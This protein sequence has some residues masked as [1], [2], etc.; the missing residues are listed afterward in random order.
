MPDILDGR[1]NFSVDQ[2]FEILERVQDGIMV[3][4]H[5]LV[6]TYANEQAGRMLGQHSRQLTGMH[7]AGLFQGAQF[8]EQAATCIQNQRVVEFEGGE[9]RP[10][11]RCACSL[12]PTPGGLISLMRVVTGTHHESLNDRTE[13]GSPDAVLQAKT[14][15]LQAANQD[16][17][18]GLAEKDLMLQIS[19]TLIA[20]EK[21]EDAIQRVADILA[22]A[23]QFDR[24]ILLTFDLG[25][26]Q[27]TGRYK[28]G[29]GVDAIFDVDFDELWDGL[30]GW[31]L[32]ERKPALSPCGTLDERESPEVRKRRTETNCGAVAVVP[33]LLQD[34]LIGTL[35]AIN[36]LDQ[37]DI[38]AADLNL[39]VLLSHQVAQTIENNR[40]YR[41]LAGEVET[42]KRAQEALLAA[43]AGL[44]ERVQQRTNELS[45][46]NRAL[47]TLSDCNQV[48]VRSGSEK[49]LMAEICQILVTTGGYHLAWV[50]YLEHNA[51]K[52]IRPV[53]WAGFEDGYLDTLH[54]T[55]IDSERG[56]G[57]TGCAARTRRISVARDVTR[58]PNFAP[59]R[60]QA[61]LRGYHSVIGVPMMLG[62]EIIGVLTIYSTRVDAFPQSEQDLLV[63]LA[64]DLA[65]GIMA[66]R[67][68]QERINLEER[69]TKAFRASP[70]AMIIA[71]M[72]DSL[73]VEVN[74]S[75]LELIGYAR[76]DLVG[77]FSRDTFSF[78]DPNEFARLRQIQEREN[79][80]HHVE[81][82]IRR[83]SGEIRDVIISIDH[84][85]INNQPH[86]LMTLVDVSDIKKMEQA[87]RES[88]TMYRLVSENTADA[89]WTIDPQTLK[90]TYVSPSVVKVH[91]F[92]AE[93]LLGAPLEMVLPPGGG[94]IIGP[95]IHERVEIFLKRGEP[96][97]FVDELDLMRKDGTPVSAEITS[98]YVRD[99]NG[100]MQVVGV[101]RDISE[102]KR[103]DALL[104]K[105]Q[106]SLEAAQA[107][108]H[109][110]SWE[111]DL[112]SGQGA[113][114]KEMFK[115]FGRDPADG[116]PEFAEFLNTIHYDDRDTLMAAHGRALETGELVTVEYRIILPKAQSGEDNH[117]VRHLESRM[118]KESGGPTGSRLAG[119][120]LD[121][122]TR[123]L[124][125]INLGERMKEL[126]CLQNVGKLLE[127]E[128]GIEL[129]EICRRI[130]EYIVQGMQF[131]D[132][133][134]VA[135]EFDGQSYEAGPYQRGLAHE[136]A[137][138][139]L[140]DRRV[141]GRIC[142]QYEQDLPFILPEE[143]NLLQNVARTLGLW[144]ERKL[145]EA[146]LRESDERF[147]QLAENVQEVFWIFDLQ[148]MRPVY[149]SPAYQTI[150]GRPV[151]RLMENPGEMLDSI[152]ADDQSIYLKAL[153]AQM[154]GE[155]ID[156]EYRIVRPN[157]AM[158]WI[159][160]RR[161]PMFDR[162]GKP[163]RS[164]GTASDVTAVKTARLELLD[165]NRT[166][167]RR[168]HERTSELS[169]ANLELAKA[170]RMKDEFLSSMSHE[171][172]TPLTGILG[173]TETLQLGVYGEINAR[174]EKALKN[175]ENSGRHL[176]ELINDILDLSKIEAG[177]LELQLEPCAVNEICQASLQLVKGMA[178]QKRLSVNF[179]TN[180]IGMTMRADGRR[181]KQMLVNLLSNAIKFTPE[182]RSVGLEL[183]GDEANGQARLT[184]WD[185]GIGIKQEDLGKLFKPFVQVDSSLSRSFSG[186]GLGLSLVQRMADMHGGSVE[187]ESEF[188]EGSRFTIV[189]P[190]T[191][192]LSMK[193]STQADSAGPAKLEHLNRL[194]TIE[195][196]LLDAEHLTYYLKTLGLENDVYGI[197]RGAVEAAAQRRPSVILL[198]LQLPDGSGLDV[199]KDLRADPRTSA[200]PVLVT[201]VSERR[202]EAAALGAA[203]YLLKPFGLDDL[204]AE[205][206]RISNQ[207]LTSEPVLVIASK[208]EYPVIMLAD[209]N[210]LIL[211]TL[212][213]FLR[214]QDYH[215]VAVPSGFELLDR[216]SSLLPDV[217]LVD[218][219]MPGMDGIE[220]IRRL[221]ALPDPALA[222]IPV[223]ALTALAMTG[224]RE[225]ILQAGAN[226][227]LSK[228]VSL[229]Q[230]SEMIRRLLQD[231]R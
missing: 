12:F 158:R 122:T 57:P 26:R 3:F 77:K 92:R 74:D 142:V 183:Q 107:L 150:W 182:G 178:Q 222:G 33:I 165:L 34:E 212:T 30:S 231:K 187:V 45:Q 203:G 134:S 16:M 98:T 217:I 29:R 128:K 83:G 23:L 11:Y 220:T 69:F 119:S 117:L 147:R 70:A 132:A 111:M 152:V 68:R 81:T 167:E 209:D 5:K 48:L 97:T 94:A 202:S 205:L 88:Q 126:T 214:A 55:W 14:E 208:S 195:D 76:E 120:L 25:T 67:T 101:T 38:S 168:V 27:V 224:D 170:S 87:L 22:M 189:L 127:D 188:G 228:P 185:K 75:Y 103:A 173:L 174:Q 36:R 99:A 46:V 54:V 93:E 227:Y 43:Q 86:N 169:I 196:N 47:R 225:K 7:A 219:Q 53:A 19:S 49:E 60:E 39:L 123:K 207:Y 59:W 157:G 15:A 96:V 64:N 135:V 95:L 125:E 146:Q 124:M 52:T 2:L 153:Q 145:S 100:H 226:E 24:V 18:Q 164:I 109:M 198:D 194:M 90:F 79:R 148:Q 190:W 118:Q 211:D 144:V 230:L 216:L 1:G 179:T 137:S 71:R 10:G 181:L 177:K 210:Q 163:V 206:A 42:R 175:V 66:Q 192:G 82:Q 199:L 58:D 186:T 201:S 40:L 149:V 155:A 44:E 156:I 31:V 160:D 28:G 37:R 56:R 159:W 229:V 176:L 121:I 20:L 197:A 21:Q 213:D 166:L 104:R 191:P 102:R 62:S 154:N 200:I 184:V 215:V 161:T 130:A 115:L 116:V 133:A 143:Q 89:I 91:G 35:T 112:E 108:A 129:G 78:A 61:L 110:G 65:Y 41:A 193:Q 73:T 131:P 218:I 50:G 140:V 72:P 162:A 106:A 138:E 172:R 80:I 139:I 85:T 17:R 32:R 114:S 105:S 9:I 221:R 141:R 223:V 204:R 8:M 113:W 151:E 4:D 180:V 171:L 63:E 13:L 51:E 6:C 84:V 136:L